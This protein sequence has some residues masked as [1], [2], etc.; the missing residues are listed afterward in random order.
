VFVRWRSC[1]LYG[2]QCLFL[3]ISSAPAGRRSE[4]FADAAARRPYHAGLERFR[5]PLW[6]SGRFRDRPSLTAAK[7][8]SVPSLHGEPT[9]CSR[10]SLGSRTR[11]FEVEDFEK[12]EFF[13]KR[14]GFFSF[15]R[16][17]LKKGKPVTILLLVTSLVLLP[18]AVAL[19]SHPTAGLARSWKIRLTLPSHF[20]YARNGG[21]AFA[22][23]N[24]WHSRPSSLARRH[25]CRRMP[26]RP[27]QSGFYPPLSALSARSYRKE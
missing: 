7:L 27:R 5:K 12:I 1:R 20:G 16:G 19:L 22:L 6:F 8:S 14:F 23:W 9:A 18:A 4:P 17:E 21:F 10:S 24:R 25:A 3:A 26:L 13:L 15:V 2:T 11:R